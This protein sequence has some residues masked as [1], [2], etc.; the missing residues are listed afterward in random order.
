MRS[1][2]RFTDPQIGRFYR[3]TSKMYICHRILEEVMWSL[4]KFYKDSLLFEAVGVFRK[5]RF[6][7]DTWKR[8]PF[9]KGV[10]RLNILRKMQHISMVCEDRCLQ[11]LSDIVPFIQ[12]SEHQ[13]KTQ[14][15]QW[16]YFIFIFEIW[17]WAK[18]DLSELS[19][20]LVCI[21]TKSASPLT[22]S[23]PLTDFRLFKGVR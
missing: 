7:K 4:V 10:I 9:C 17:K 23:P 16:K 11:T 12:R 19:A 21:A 6:F 5:W 22:V 18:F 1:V 20:I 15:T 8:C 13:S 3:W 2:V 14:R